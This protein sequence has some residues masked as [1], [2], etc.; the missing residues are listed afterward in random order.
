MTQVYAVLYT[1][2]G[3][4]LLA[5]KN[6]RYYFVLNDYDVGEV[7]PRGTEPRSGGGRPALPGGEKKPTESV[8]AC[9]LR[10]FREETGFSGPI[11]RQGYRIL[12]SDRGYE[13]CCI[14]VTPEVFNEMA[15]RIIG[16]HLPA[17]EWA[18]DMVR[19]DPLISYDQLMAL[20]PR[21]PAA[22]ELASAKIV[23]IVDE[24]SWAE[25][26]L[27]LNQAGTEWYYVILRELRI[28]LRSN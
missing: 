9:A 8:L 12:S 16:I 20:N 2:E 15:N 3:N 17:G 25:V 13:A 26:E 24:V 14:Q 19:H 6:F 18:A 27:E 1:L 4:V 22:N 11:D 5:R 28:L 7:R 10:E 23:N 21:S